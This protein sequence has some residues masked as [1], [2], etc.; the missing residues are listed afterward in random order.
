MTKLK[1]LIIDDH[2][3]M[4]EGYKSILSFN[5]IGYDLDIS[6]A[7]N[8]EEAFKIITTLNNPIPFDVIFLDLKLPAYE[9]E[10]INSGK[11]L[12]RLIQKHLP[13]SKIVILTSHAEAIIL[14]D[15]IQNIN[16]SGLLVKSDFTAQDLLAAFEQIIKGEIYYSDTVKR[17]IKELLSKDFYLD[18]YNRQIVLLLSQGIKTKNLP[19]YIPLSISAIDKRKSQIKDYFNISKGNDDE[20]I[21][22]AKRTGLV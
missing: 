3:L 10:N 11:D 15:V 2:Y 9:S 14:Y 4:V 20:I 13:E 8:C 6:K 17:S 12:A 21:R 1:I 22:E 16:P 19:D 7:H 5:N 18:N